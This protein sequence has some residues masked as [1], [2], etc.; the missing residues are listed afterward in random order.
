VGVVWAEENI[1]AL[2][3]NTAKPRKYRGDT[4]LTALDRT[5]Y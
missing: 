5:N 2:V 4:L 1:V 3:Q